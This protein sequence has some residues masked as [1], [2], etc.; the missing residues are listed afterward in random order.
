VRSVNYTLKPASIDSA[1]P[2]EKAYP[3][4]DGGGL[5][6]DVLPSGSKIWRYKYHYS[7]KREKVTIG[8]YPQ[9]G[10][11]AARDG[12][13]K[14]RISLA[15][16]TSPAKAKRAQKT[17]AKVAAARDV[18]FREFAQRWIEETLFYRSAGYRAQTA[19]WLDQYVY[20][21]IGDLPLSNVAPADVLAIVEARRETAVTA[22]RV[23]TIV[24]QIYNY[25]IKKLL[26][27]SNPATP[28]RGLVKRPPV[29]NHRHLSEKELGAFWRG[30]V[31]QGA[32][33]STIAAAKL[34][35]LTMT[36]KT[37][38]LRSTWGEF[39]L[40]AGLWDI[41]A[42]R[43]KNRKVHRVFLSTQA[44]QIL[45]ELLPLT[46][47]GSYVFPSIFRG[48]VPMGDAT[49]NHFFK[50]IDFGVPKFSPH[51][52]RGTAATMLRENGF[53]REVVELLL[54]HSEESATVAAY[55]HAEHVGERRRA[56][57]FLANRIDK[58]AAGG[59]V[60]HL[61]AA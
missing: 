12:H 5:Y 48:S 36:R 8:P 41:P 16:G 46:G 4:T 25:A 9:I 54:S 57:Q 40:D 27:T 20:P 38:L 45:R 7:G 56:M 22:E 58:L 37:E 29:Q 52:T 23:R 3:L 28:L 55:S 31:K 30:V 1:K 50:R 2:R 43:M 13:E 59:D 18:T 21:K 53:A 34:L 61:K 14:L 6:V 49:L 32:H 11:K 26:V 47:Q 39:D 19:R 42:P 51:G 17:D 35:M 33:A 24:Q 15:E 44:V 60:K 10:I